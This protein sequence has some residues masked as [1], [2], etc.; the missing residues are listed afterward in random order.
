MS[1]TRCS[2]SVQ[3]FCLSAAVR[4]ATASTMTKLEATTHPPGP[5]PPPFL[6]PTAIETPHVAARYELHR[7]ANSADSSGHAP[8]PY[9]PTALHTHSPIFTLP[10]NEEVFFLPFRFSS[11]FSLRRLCRR[12]R[13]FMNHTHFYFYYYFNR[14]LHPTISRVENQTSYKKTNLVA[15]TMQIQAKQI[16]QCATC[17]V[18]WVLGSFHLRNTLMDSPT[19]T[20]YTNLSALEMYDSY[21]YEI[22]GATSKDGFSSMRF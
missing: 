20:V 18:I 6:Y 9:P 7:L 5:A 13:G 2:R 14:L 16:G 15:E 11:P 4:R 19:Y 10:L 1:R 8:L 12:R 17:V 22:L 21:I 3:F